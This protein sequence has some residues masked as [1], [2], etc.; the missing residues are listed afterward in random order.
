MLL[1]SYCM[2]SYVAAFHLPILAPTTNPTPPAMTCSQG[3]GHKHTH[4]RR[5]P[6]TRVRG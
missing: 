4:I 6:M 3:P 5:Q 2:T 1:F